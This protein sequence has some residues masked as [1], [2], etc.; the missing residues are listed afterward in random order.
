MTHLVIQAPDLAQ[1][2]IEHVS[3]LAHARRVVELAPGAVR[4]TEADAS[5][6]VRA[7]V[8]AYC[9]QARADWAYVE[10]G[11]RLTDWKVLAMDMDSTLI[12]IECIDEIADMAG[13]KPQVAAITEAAMRGEIADFSESLTRRV[14]LLQ[15]L[16]LEALEQVYV[17]RL[18][19]NP[20]A[21]RLLLAAH[22]AGIKTLLVS[23]GFTWFTG[24][25]QQ[26]LQLNEAH[27]NTL[28]VDNGRLT[29]KVRGAI[30]DAEG[31]AR[32]L[33]EFA[34]RHGA[35]LAQAIA[36]G[37]GANDLKMLGLAGLSVAYHAKPVVREQTT[38][39]LDVC[40][41]D[42]ILNWFEDTLG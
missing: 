41:L 16:P 19:L 31:K 24:R 18:R 13:L 9:Q 23:G 42:G 21:E 40:G 35:P 25:L 4:L 39:A 26:R 30:L 5:P 37:D 28:E 2:S 6:A 29:G 38:R 7:Q 15:G 14:A 36:V 1:T 12:N 22:R 10:P 8:A 32:H 3:R 20:G 11:A 17:E 33:R 34:Q 27:A